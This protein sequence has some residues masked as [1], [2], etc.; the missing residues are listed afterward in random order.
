VAGAE[1][2]EV[3]VREAL[4]AGRP[5]LPLSVRHELARLLLDGGRDSAVGARTARH[6]G[7]GSA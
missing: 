3:L 4:A 5:A 7:E 6:G 1:Q 2:L